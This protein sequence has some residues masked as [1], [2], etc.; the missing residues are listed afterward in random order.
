MLFKI[1]Q[2]YCL[3]GGLCCLKYKVF[4]SSDI[5]KSFGDDQGNESR[6]VTVYTITLCS[7][8]LHIPQFTDY[9]NLFE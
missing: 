5:I 4:L 7:H 2:E 6:P 8:P 3:V 9:I 1:V